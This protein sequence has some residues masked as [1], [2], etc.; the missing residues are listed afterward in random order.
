MHTAVIGSRTF[1]DYSFLRETLEQYP[2]T[3]IVSG[4]AKGADQLSEQYAHEKG[5]PTQIFKPDYAKSGKAAPLIH[6]QDIVN[7]AD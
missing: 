6:N 2:I 3:Q 4:G 1:N 7:A 5:L